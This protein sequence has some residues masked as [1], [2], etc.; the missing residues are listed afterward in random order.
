VQHHAMRRRV[1]LADRRL[2]ECV[3]PALVPARGAA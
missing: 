1:S 3:G 2:A